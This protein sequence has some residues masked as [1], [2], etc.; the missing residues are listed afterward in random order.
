MKE[1]LNKN[2]KKEHSMQKTL[3]KCI[4]EEDYPG[5]NFSSPRYDMKEVW[6]GDRGVLP[7]LPNYYVFAP[8]KIHTSG[9]I[10]KKWQKR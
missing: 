8:L 10:H 9:R 5:Y 2:F 3:E 7:F 4:L 1:K 6:M